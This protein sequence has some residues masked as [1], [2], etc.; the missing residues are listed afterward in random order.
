MK[1]VVIPMTR[2]AG[3]F[4]VLALLA[5][6]AFADKKLDDA[7]AKAEEQ[8]QK[9]KPDEAI[10]GLQR[11]VQGSPS[12]EGWLALARFQERLGNLD[13]AMKSAVAALAG[14]SSPALKADTLAVQSALALLMGTGK[15]AVAQA[16]AAVN[17]QATPL[18]LAALARAQVRTQ[19]PAAAL[20]SAEK[21]VAAGATSAV[22]HEARGDA[23]L[24]LGRKDDAVAAYRKALELDPKGSRARVGLAT[25][26]S[27][28]G[29]HAEAV[30]EAKKVTAAE[31]KNAEAFAALGLALLGETPGNWTAAIAEAQQGAF[32]NPKS[33]NVQVAVGR[34]FEAA[35][36]LDQAKQAYERA[37][38]IDPG[39]NMPAS[40]QLRLVREK[41]PI[42]YFQSLFDKAKSAPDWSLD[43]GH[44]LLAADKAWLEYVTLRDR[45]PGDGDVQAEMVRL[46]FSL[47]DYKGAA[48]AARAATKAAPNSAEV[49]A[50][51]G[52]ALLRVGE[53]ELARDAYKKASDLDPKNLSYRSSYGLVLGM[54]A[55]YDAGVTELLKVTGSPGYQDSAGWTN[56]GWLYRNMTP[57]KMQ[58]AVAAYKKAL[59]L[60][61]KNA[62]AAIGMGWVYSY[63]EKYD[64]AI[65]AFHR[66]A[67]I[68]SGM[69][70]D[71]MNGAAWCY[72]FKKDMAQAT[73]FLEKAQAAGR[74]DPRLR[75]N[76]KKVAQL[77]EKQE[78]YDKWFKEQEELRRRGPDVGTLC[79]QA[80]SGDAA[81]KMTA[82]Q[83]LGDS[84]RDG[85]ACLIRALDDS[86]A[87]VR[88]AAADELGGMGPAG[89]QALPY[90]MEVLR[91][92]CG[93]T[94][95]E[96]K[97]LEES[98][99]CED[100]KKKARDAV[101]K[102]NR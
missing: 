48:N 49:N 88:G 76:I 2:T 80:S 43:K 11:A 100:A 75:E 25:A 79:R 62:Q 60:D 59:E 95:M 22:A 96:K 55:Q 99:K 14:A 81:S 101:Q 44:A 34:I 24:A 92:E 54:N 37:Q 74:S 57:K 70:A 29:K 21:A 56:L 39:A 17:A 6:P 91:A 71:A 63:Q 28:A 69:T 85:V 20:Q 12:T 13:D 7:V 35:G 77:K 5:A 46:L 82:I 10:K 1:G 27:A 4:F 41:H 52:A 83:H 89:K 18:A 53:T 45:F 8:L 30:A 68:D 33:A 65:P 50:I 32:L 16:Q 93:K 23:L 42:K 102:I 3:T 26:L 73:A 58:E 31:E 72:F 9:G 40:V 66:A 51:A 94:I 78:A 19:D 64:E 61:P 38:T 67:Q 98:L 36:N 86:Q 90:L 15:D 84:G 87:E 97:E 47:E